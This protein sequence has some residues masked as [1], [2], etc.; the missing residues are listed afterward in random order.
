MDTGSRTRA[1]AEAALV[2]ALAA[3]LDF[4]R[5]PLPYLLYGGSVSLE[6]LP[7][8]VVGLRRGPAAGAVA[9]AV[10]GLVNLMLH[11]MVVHPAQVV[12]DYPLAYG[13]L[14][15]GAGLSGG[16]AVRWG[17]VHRWQ[18]HLRTAVG[19]L[20][21]NAG[22][23]LSH[24]VSGIA[25][26]AAYAPPGQ[27]VWK[28][29]L[30]YNGSYML[31]QSLLQILLVPVVVRILAQRAASAPVGRRGAGADRLARPGQQG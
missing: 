28:Y 19:V 4:A 25:F 27:A 31:P 11:P 21:G 20:A 14:G 30:V 1:H 29:S 16:P 12:L 26:F 18:G 22:R 13:L 2:V 17:T 10:Y 24:F 15:L 7:L 6:G 23:L 3:V 9:G 5:I 8:I